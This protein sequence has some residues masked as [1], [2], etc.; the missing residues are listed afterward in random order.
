ML[1]SLFCSL[2]LY[3]F[4]F[5]FFSGKTEYVHARV[6]EPARLALEVPFLTP[7]VSD[8]WEI[9]D[10]HSLSTNF[11]NSGCSHFPLAFHMVYHCTSYM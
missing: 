3:L 10:R 5:P 11:A 8:E 2:H 9:Y 1:P 6:T 4:V 7:H